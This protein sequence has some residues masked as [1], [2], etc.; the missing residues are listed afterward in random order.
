MR[1]LGVTIPTPPITPG[2]L[3]ILA[4]FL[5]AHPSARASREA[6]KHHDSLNGNS[7]KG[8]RLNTWSSVGRTVWGGLEG[9]DLL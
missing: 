7:P 1:S 4:F 6:R 2:Y 5:M 8:S 3:P 9:M